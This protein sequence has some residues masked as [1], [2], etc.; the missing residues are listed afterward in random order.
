MPHKHLLSHT[1]ILVLTI[2]VAFIMTD[3]IGRNY[4]LEISAFLFVAYV[5]GKKLL[6]VKETA[7]GSGTHTL[8]DSVIFT[9][10]ILNIVLTTGGLS[11]SMFFL[12]YFL[13]FALALM[14][15]PITSVTSVIAIVFLFMFDTQR[16]LTTE[17][18]MAIISLPFLVPF[19][20]YFGKEHRI[21]EKQK[22]KIRSLE[23]RE[24]DV[25]QDS[26]IFVST[27][28]RG[29]LNKISELAQN[30]H[31]DH[32]LKRIQKVVRRTQKLIDTFEDRY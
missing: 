20:L 22:T 13:I 7:H 12:V 15:E 19:A 28:I 4:D 29:H 17:H 26:L 27:V 21:R 9:L 11:S 23:S 5:I 16:S 10:I 2:F 30:F 18:I 6:P 3:T 14:L 31:G 1:V 24:S 8:Y 25:E 32:E